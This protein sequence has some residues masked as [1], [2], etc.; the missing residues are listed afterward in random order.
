M[1]I[2]LLP[3]VVYI[4]P[5]GRRCRWVPGPWYTQALFKYLDVQPPKTDGFALTE[6]NYHLLQRD[7]R[8]A[9]A[10]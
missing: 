3:N 10:R 9:P 2:P 1:S 4:T 6:A 8:H 5:T 7:A